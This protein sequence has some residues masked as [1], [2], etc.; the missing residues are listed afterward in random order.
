MV[1]TGD[2]TDDKFMNESS[3]WSEFAQLTL[4]FVQYGYNGMRVHASAHIT[5]NTLLGTVTKRGITQH[6]CHLMWHH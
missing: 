1:L 5:V 6:S 4:P 3:S 2:Q